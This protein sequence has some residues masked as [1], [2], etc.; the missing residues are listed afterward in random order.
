VGVAITNAN[1][2]LNIK[3]HNY[4]VTIKMVDKMCKIWRRNRNI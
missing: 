1:I 2:N 4:G 3:R